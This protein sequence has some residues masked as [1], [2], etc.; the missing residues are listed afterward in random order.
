MRLLDGG[1]KAKDPRGYG[2]ENTTASVKT[3]QVGSNAAKVGAVVSSNRECHLTSEGDESFSARASTPTG[4]IFRQ[5]YDRMKAEEEIKVQVEPFSQCPMRSISSTMDPAFISDNF[6]PLK[7]LSSETMTSPATVNTSTSAGSEIVTGLSPEQEEEGAAKSYTDFVLSKLL[8]LGP[9]DFA[10][11]S[12]VFSDI[13]LQYQSSVKDIGLKSVKP[14]TR[15]DLKSLFTF[16]H[17]AVRECERLFA[18]FICIPDENDMKS[19]LENL[20]KAPSSVLQLPPSLQTT[21]EVVSKLFQEEYM[22]RN[23][24]VSRLE[25]ENIQILIEKASQYY[26]EELMANQSLTPQQFNSTESTVREDTERIFMQACDFKHPSMKLA[27]IEKLMSSLNKVVKPVQANKQLEKI[28]KVAIQVCL[29]TMKQLQMGLTLQERIIALESNERKAHAAGYRHF[30]SATDNLLDE[31]DSKIFLQWKQQLDENLKDILRKKRTELSQAQRELYVRSRYNKLSLMSPNLYDLPQRNLVF[32]MGLDSTRVGILRSNE[33]EIIEEVENCLYFHDGYQLRFFSPQYSPVNWPNKFSF[34]R[35]ILNDHIGISYDV[36]TGAEES[37]VRLE[38]ILSFFFL[39]LKMKYE[40]AQKVEFRSCTIVVPQCLNGIQRA[41]IQDSAMIAGFIP[42]TL[43]NDT[44]AIAIACMFERPEKIQRSIVV[45]TTEENLFDVAS[46]EIKQGIIRCLGIT[47]L[48]FLRDT[49]LWDKIIHSRFA[50]TIASNFLLGSDPMEKLVPRAFGP[51]E[52]NIN[53]YLSS[54]TYFLTQN[55]LLSERCGQEISEN[56]SHD[57]NVIDSNCALR[58]A[59]YFVALNEPEFNPIQHCWSKLLNGRKVDSALKEFREAILTEEKRLSKATCNSCSG[60]QLT[61]KEF[62]TRMDQFEKCDA[63]ATH[64]V[65]L[66]S[67]GCVQ[68]IQNALPYCGIDNDTKMQIRDQVNR[69]CTEL[70]KDDQRSE[71]GHFQWIRTELN[72][73]IHNFRLG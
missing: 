61:M 73:L 65:R 50:K 49:S 40:L 58:G 33:A 54:T 70:Q 29:E 16:L 42:V 28:I 10:L 72:D 24:V 43:I 71:I 18:S 25:S 32:H 51:E 4:S 2:S 48:Y 20:L 55:G 27:S 37:S 12:R 62:Q 30:L 52:L 3:T 56:C 38:N 59:I 26:M 66:Q 46:F 7:A 31:M 45:A 35:F 6:V 22:E 9:K 60:T 41:C 14:E 1:P 53:P 63:V 5:N 34:K 8:L 64:Q 13:E 39:N 21:F 68:K 23:R 69:L 57:Y 15:Q 36:K 67:L 47:G 17:T 44:N 11:N 19:R